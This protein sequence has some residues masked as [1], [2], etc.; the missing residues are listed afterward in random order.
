MR[1]LG[2]LSSVWRVQKNEA[3]NVTWADCDFAKSEITVRGDPD[4]GT[5][6]GAIRTI[7]MI[8]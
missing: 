2:A 1:R 6:S 3:A 8:S 4:T 5:K 7:P